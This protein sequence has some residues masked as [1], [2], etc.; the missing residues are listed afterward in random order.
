MLISVQPIG[1]YQ[2]VQNYRKPKTQKTVYISANKFR[3]FAA[4]IISEE[5]LLPKVIYDS[6][7]CLI[8]PQ[9]ESSPSPPAGNRRPSTTSD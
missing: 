8:Y 4:T 5:H 6:L 9:S 7:D 2:I 3:F 1:S